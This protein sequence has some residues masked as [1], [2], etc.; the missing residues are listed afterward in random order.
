MVMHVESFANKI[1]TSFQKM[2]IHICLMKKNNTNIFPFKK[3]KVTHSRTCLIAEV[4]AVIRQMFCSGKFAELMALACRHMGG[5]VA[6]VDAGQCHLC[7]RG[8]RSRLLAYS[9]G[10]VGGAASL[11]IPRFRKNNNKSDSGV[12]TKPGA[13]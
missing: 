12:N 7:S 8:S 5:R 9:G 2:A 3:N 1:V 6:G 13:K 11:L 4:K 10:G